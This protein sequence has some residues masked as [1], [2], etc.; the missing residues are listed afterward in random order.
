VED[1]GIGRPWRSRSVLFGEFVGSEQTMTRNLLG[2]GTGAE[3]VKRI[4]ALYSPE[5]FPWRALP[6]VGSV[7]TVTLIP[8]ESP[9]RGL[10]LSDISAYSSPGAGMH[11]SRFPPEGVSWHFCSY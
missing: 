8:G 5:R 1:T 7:F 3:H 9:D 6:D 4:A 11:R 10:T 2:S